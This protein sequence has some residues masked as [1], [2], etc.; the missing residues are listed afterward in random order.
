MTGFE[1]QQF[2]FDVDL[3]DST[4]NNRHLV[5]WP[6]VYILNR[7]ARSTTQRGRIYIGESRNFNTRMKQHLEGKKDLDLRTVRVV[8]DDTF[9]KSVCL[10]LESFLISLAF[11]DGE[12][13]VLN[14]NMGISNADYYRRDRYQETFGEI[15]DELR[16]AGLFQ[17]SI[18]E[19]VNSELFKLSPFKALNNDQGLAIMDILE[20]LSEDLVASRELGSMV[21]VQGDPGTG[22]TIVAIYLAKLLR[23][24]SEFSGGEDIDGDEMFSEFFVEG[25]RERFRN[26]KI[27]VVVPQQALRRSF[28]RVFAATPGL[29]K[30]MVMS[31][32]T[33]AESPDTFDV[34][35]VDEAHRLNQYSSQ[36]VP[37]LTKRFNNIN[38]RLFNGENPQASQL[39]WLMK[40]SR[41]V[42]LML[43]LAQSIRP[44]DLPKEEF[45]ALLTSVPD[46]RNYRLHTQMRSLGGR[47]YIKYVQE[48][49]SP[50]PPT[51][52]LNFEGYDLA[53]IDSPAEFDSTIKSLEQESGLSRIVAGYA[54]DWVSK[55]DPEAFDID[56]GDGV[57]YQWN[58]AV[59][60]WVSSDNAVNEAGSIHTIQGYDLNYA[61]VIV[62]ADLRYTPELGLFAEKSNYFDR[63]GKKSNKM[64]GQTTTEQD[65]LKYIT[66]I[67]AV[68]LTRAIKGTF[69]YVIDPGLREYLGR[70]FPVKG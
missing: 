11:G 45:Q 65:L 30:S 49:L 63:Q 21:V 25:T 15:F 24:I 64:R 34:L 7:P 69:L 16:N 41:H 48:V 57:R 47:D 27:G 20:G 22:K 3:I 50:I 60:D 29:E 44:N 37:A 26:L 52:R 19:I 40:K 36:S 2:D 55:K 68:L 59:V 32:F 66:N 39:E 14:R 6:V 62:G 53:I 8:L 10:D 42:I 28:E 9:N 67:Y 51:E 18:P 35:I 61:G 58:T 56:L 43:D 5:N 38:Q 54:W 70:Y 31:A 33:V 12:N 13:E 4:R 46:N 23:D 17:R 1:I